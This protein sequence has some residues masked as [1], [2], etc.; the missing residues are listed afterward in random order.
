MA[1]MVT[2]TG[3]LIPL[4]YTPH[5]DLFSSQ[6]NTLVAIQDDIKAI[7]LNTY[8]TI[9]NPFWNCKDCKEEEVG[10]VRCSPWDVEAVKLESNDYFL[11]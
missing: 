3:I 5:N 4:F 10:F 1:C 2:S 9:M 6:C 11:F 7:N 8:D